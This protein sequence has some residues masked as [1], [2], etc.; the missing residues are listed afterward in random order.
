MD[1]QG[2]L[3]WWF[4]L[5]VFASAVTL[6]G[7]VGIESARVAIAD[8]AAAEASRQLQVSAMRVATADAIRIAGGDPAEPG[9][10]EAVEALTGDHRQALGSLSSADAEAA[11]ALLVEIAGCGTWLLDPGAEVHEVHGHAELQ[12]LLDSAATS[13]SADAASAERNA[14]LAL[15]A[16]L[17]A[18]AMGLGLIVMS[19]IRWDRKQTTVASEAQAAQR[20][21][22]LLGDSPDVFVVIDPDGQISYRSPSAENLFSPAVESRDDIVALVQDGDAERLR[23]HLDRTDVDGASEVFNFVDVNGVS[24]CFELRVSDLTGDPAVAGH[25]L[26]ARDVTHEH[27]LKEELRHQATTD[28]LTGIPNRRMLPHVLDAIRNEPR[29]A[30][31]GI[32]FVLLDIN[33]FRAIN[34]SL[35]TDTGDQL[36]QLAATR[37]GKAIEPQVLLRL[38]SDEFATILPGQLSEVQVLDYAKKLQSVFVEP[39]QVA[40]RTERLSVNVGVAIVETP[41]EAEDL[42]RRAEIALVAAKRSN[43]EAPVVY[44]SSL[45]ETIARRAHIRRALYSAVYDNEFEIVYQPIVSSDTSQ[46][47]GLEALLRWNSPT[48]GAVRPD[49]FIPIAED[50]GDIC[51]IGRW[52]VENVCRQVSS[53][54]E[55]G[56]QD[57]VTV[58][59][60]VSARQLAEEDFVQFVSLEAEM[61]G[62]DPKRIIVEVTETAALDEQGT[63]IGRL[64]ELKEAGFRISIDDFGSGYSNLGQL[65]RVPFDVL[66]ID[67]SLLLMLTDMRAAQ[68]GDASDPCQILE[69]VVS[70]A[71]ILGVPVVCEGVE[72]DEQRRSLAASRVTYVQGY[73]T[74]RPASAAHT[75]ELLGLSGLSIQRSDV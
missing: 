40:G 17:G 41:D 53:W 35:G 13:A 10:D 9:L 5:A 21:V 44:E 8:R 12:T 62:I 63:A 26:T 65:L 56:M 36:L 19:R 47:S 25:V 72:T 22:A 48:L 16:A 55:I 57:H 59:L 51:E 29:T 58:S 43:S 2:G 23:W 7:V 49:E 27:L 3:K 15:L 71:E 46:L 66:K 31:A 20:L 68:G 1:R 4:T 24:G 32:A 42:H 70:I 34:D 50:A 52:V 64:G 73:L 37:L 69:A 30:E 39:F 6:S 11:T 75:A 54:S 18:L 14:A 67:R 74:G 60:N 28:A 45:D 61:W 33:G 38:G